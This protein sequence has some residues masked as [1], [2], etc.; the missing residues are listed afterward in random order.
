[1]GDHHLRL[2]WKNAD[3]AWMPWNNPAC[4]LDNA[5]NWKGTEVSSTHYDVVRGDQT[6]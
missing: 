4:R 2:H 1:M 3:D 5:P 6:C